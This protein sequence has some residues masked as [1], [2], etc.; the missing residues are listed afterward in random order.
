MTRSPRVLAMGLAVGSL[1]IGGSAI[2]QPES[3]FDTTRL[4]AMLTA[5]DSPD[6]PVRQDTTRM[7]LENA[8]VI[9]PMLGGSSLLSRLS[10]E[11][12][13]R[14]LRVL[15][16]AFYETPRGGLGVSFAPQN[17]GQGAMLGNV[18]PNFPA[19]KTLRAGDFVI[20][21]DGERLAAIAN[22]QATGLLRRA[23]ISRDPGE[24]LSMRILREGEEL[25]VQVELGSYNDLNTASIPFDELF[26][27]WE[28]RVR[29]LALSQTKQS[30][31]IDVA[32]STSWRPDRL[33]LIQRPE[34]STVVPGGRSALGSFRL[35]A[36]SI[37]RTNNARMMLQQ[38]ER[39]DPIR[40]DPDAS[41]EDLGALVQQMEQMRNELMNLQL[42]LNDDSLTQAERR[43][44]SQ[45]VM[46]VEAQIRA[47]R[48]RIE[49]LPR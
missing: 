44:M 49:A 15:E 19:S 45:Q 9:A 26:N 30:P 35:I 1:L 6:L 33:R 17:L 22:R 32:S 13:G 21:V 31:G 34:G 7:L 41:D 2:A 16:R 25:D 4:N 27:A 24:Y 38:Q 29:R 5:L 48:Q 12:R 42:L 8:V 10:P 47:L 39:G 14:V 43:V 23:I 18:L 40:V 20:G 3:R 37:L 11:Q 36:Q 46:R 28:Y